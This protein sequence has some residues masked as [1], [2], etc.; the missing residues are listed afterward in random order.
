MKTFLV[1]LLGFSLSC[2]VV[3]GQK[4][5]PK[6]NDLNP[7]IRLE[8]G[9]EKSDNQRVVL[10]SDIDPEWDKWKIRGYHFGF[11]PELTPMYT[12]V[13]GILSTPYMIQVRGN[14]NESNKKRWGYHLFEGYARDN[15]S[16]LTMLVN[17]HLELEKPVAEIYYYGTAYN[18]SNQAYNWVKIGSDVKNH[19][20][21]FTRDQAVFYGSLNLT[22]T[23]TLGNIRR[24]NL[25][26]EPPE[27][28]SE[29]NNEASAQHVNYKALQEGGNGTMFY[30]A[31]HDIVV[32]KVEGKWMKL[33]V[34]P[35][36]EG[37]EYD[38]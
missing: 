27:G 18:H 2:S 35:L 21:M 4:N 30:D 8:K 25:R 3:Y 19:S 24:K 10:Q 34:E 14:D 26:K 13:D 29:Q 16:R 9:S 7:Y 28:D 38:F 15:K 31:D 37:V 23:L 5:K 6:S 36:P 11:N 32:I 22:N 33:K 20:F 17:K 12:S 1:L